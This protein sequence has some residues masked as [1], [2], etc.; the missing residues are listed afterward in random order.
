MSQTERYHV[1]TLNL[2]NKFMVNNVNRLTTLESSSNNKLLDQK[3]LG[4]WMWKETGAI[5]YKRGPFWDRLS[6]GWKDR[7]RPCFSWRRI[8][9]AAR[10]ISS[11]VISNASCISRDV[12]RTKSGSQN[13]PSPCCTNTCHVQWENYFIHSWRRKVTAKLEKQNLRPCKADVET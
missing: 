13:L 6:L 2:H 11:A 12:H 10:S 3:D 1:N 4:T 7:G 9:W 8:R 5:G